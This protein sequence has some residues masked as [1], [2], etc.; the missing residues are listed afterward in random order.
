MRITDSNRLT[1][2][3]TRLLLVAAVMCSVAA[4]RGAMQAANPADGP[5][6]G[7]V[8]CQLTAQS[9]NPGQPYRHEQTHTWVLTGST[10]L[11]TS[12]D[13]IKQYAATWQVTGQG[14]RRRGQSANAEQW[15][16]EGQPM[17]DTITIRLTIDKTLRFA[18]APQLRSVGTTTGTAM[19]YVEEWPFPVIDV[20]ATQSSISGSAPSAT[21]PNFPGAPPATP[22]SGTCS[23]NLVRGGAAPPPPGLSLPSSLSR[24][25]PVTTG[26]TAGLAVPSRPGTGAEAPAVPPTPATIANVPAQATAGPT[27]T[28]P[29]VTV[30][31]Q[32]SVPNPNV[33]RLAGPKVVGYASGVHPGA[34]HLEWAYDW[35][36]YTQSRTADSKN[37]M[38]SEYTITRAD[39]G[40]TRL[41]GGFA[42]DPRPSFGRGANPSFDHI[43][44]FDYRKTYTYKI[45]SRHFRQDFSQGRVTATYE[46]GCGETEW[47]ITP[48]RPQTPILTRSVSGGTG[49]TLEWKMSPEQYQTGFLVTGAGLP[50]DG[51]TVPCCT[52]QLANT[53]AGDLTWRIAP[54]WDTPEGRMIDV[55]TALRVGPAPSRI[56]VQSFPSFDIVNNTC[57]VNIIV[58]WVPVGGATGYTV[59]SDGKPLGA[60]IPLTTFSFFYRQADMRL[61]DLVGGALLSALYE[62]AQSKY[63]SQPQFS[64]GLNIQVAASVAGSPDSVSA[65]DPYGFSIFPCVDGRNFPGDP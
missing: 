33:C 25:T 23:W 56:R 58:T 16:T 26:R 44:K 14:T 17:P 40:N 47:T 29:R 50:S 19:P 36:A 20:P 32:V 57:S 30:P 35:E 46:D 39:L 31:G 61:S 60:R 48:P 51:R 13:A 18:G 7:W 2:Q 6:S 5:W 45:R 24:D 42:S 64:R 49:V 41:G 8:Q 22:S 43:A 9:T 53:P 3:R 37:V 15:T 21:Q 4:E 1:V 12:T 63:S 59:L 65:A 10:P 11:P 52:F 28:Q 54:Y 62:A 55:D 38:D 27:P 34:A